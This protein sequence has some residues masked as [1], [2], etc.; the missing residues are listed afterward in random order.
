MPQQNA[1]VGRQAER[2]LDVIVSVFIVFVWRQT[3]AW[4][5]VFVWRQTTPW[6]YVGWK[7]KNFAIC[8]GRLTLENCENDTRPASSSQLQLYNTNEENGLHHPILVLSLRRLIPVTICHITHTHFNFNINRS[9]MVGN[10]ADFRGFTNSTK[11]TRWWY[12]QY[13]MRSNK[14]EIV[15][16]QSRKINF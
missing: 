4:S 14:A 9:D 15:Q 13:Y 5:Y 2:W 6:S 8:S 12:E 16:F 1:L 3:T 11:L 7:E 10:C